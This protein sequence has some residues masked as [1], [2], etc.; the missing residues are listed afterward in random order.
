MPRIHTLAQDSLITASD[1]LVGS[2]GAQNS[3]FVT[4]NYSVGGIKN[5]VLDGTHA[6]SFTTITTTGNGTIGGNL[7]VTGDLSVTGNATIAG[8][9]TFGNANTDTV[10]FSADVNSHVMPDVTNTYDLGAS[11][12]IWRNI[13]ADNVEGYLK[14]ADAATTYLALAGGTL[15]GGL[16][17]TTATF[18]GNLQL[19][20]ATTDAVSEIKAYGELGLR[21]DSDNDTGYSRGVEIFRTRFDMNGIQIHLNKNLY[22]ENNNLVP[23]TAFATIEVG[24]V[25]YELGNYGANYQNNTSEAITSVDGWYD[26]SDNFVHATDSTGA[27]Y[28]RLTVANGISYA[29]NAYLTI[30]PAGETFVSGGGASSIKFYADTTTIGTLNESLFSIPGKATIGAFTIPNTIGTA[31]QV[32]SVPSSGSELEWKNLNI[33]GYFFPSAAGTAGQVLKIP[34]SGTQLEWGAAA[35][36]SAV[37]GSGT[38]TVPSSV[39][40]FVINI[41]NKNGGM[42]IV[43]E[44]ALDGGPKFRLATNTQQN[45]FILDYD[46]ATT[47]VRMQRHGAYF[48]KVDADGLRADSPVKIGVGTIT[49]THIDYDDLVIDNNQNA[50]GIQVISNEVSGGKST[51]SLGKNIRKNGAQLVYHTSSEEVSIVRH[52]SAQIVIDANKIN[53]FNRVRVTGL[54]VFADE[55][56]ATTG[57]LV[58]GDLYRTATGEIRI[59]L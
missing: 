40:D 59:K 8:N 48:L 15:T 44:D 42:A 32:L 19:G 41:D 50:S 12:K 36:A 24:D 6:G 11:D 29:S 26:S 14:S 3:G 33:N 30:L 43:T 51:I 21:A 37:V 49:N 18:T 22:D 52:G 46:K 58:A 9:L 45:A 17:G 56:A 39:N 13:Y 1:K 16:I 28:F 7:S 54:Y 31:E 47:A 38:N 10:S 5:F 57:G 2:D 4:R 55:A 23:D 53:L 20:D 34:T 35:T 25:V 27:A